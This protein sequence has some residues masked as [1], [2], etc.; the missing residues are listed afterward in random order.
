MNAHFCSVNAWQHRSSRY[1][2]FPQRIGM[3]VHIHIKIIQKSS[4]HLYWLMCT[5]GKGPTKT[6]WVLKRRRALRATSSLSDCQ[7]PRTLASSIGA[8]PTRRTLHDTCCICCSSPEYS[9]F[10][11]RKQAGHWQLSNP[12]LFQKGFASEAVIFQQWMTSPFCDFSREPAYDILH[13]PLGG[14]SHLV[15]GLVHPSYKWDFCRLN[16]LK[17]LGWTNPLTI[18]EMSH[19]HHPPL[20]TRPGISWAPALRVIA[21][22]VTPSPRP[23]PNAWRRARP[24]VTG[25]GTWKKHEPHRGIQRAVA[26]CRSLV[27]FWLVFTG[28]PDFRQ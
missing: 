18:R 25:C 27:G 13:T 22:M 17:K 28:W 15:G 10:L 7:K 16:P 14:S 9:S 6:A 3:S 11:P 8:W 23:R 12:L 19:H 21:P 24:F 5:P 26:G 1:E 20:R 4:P 2:F